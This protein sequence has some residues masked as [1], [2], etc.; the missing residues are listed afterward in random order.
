M[1]RDHVKVLDEVNIHVDNGGWNIALY[2]VLDSAK[3]LDGV[4]IE[5]SNQFYGYVVNTMRLT[6]GKNAAPIGAN[7]LEVLGKMFIQAAENIRLDGMK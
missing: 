4:E 2:P 5:I 7:E 1:P 6:A 3:R